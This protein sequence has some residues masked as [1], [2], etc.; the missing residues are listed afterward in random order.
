MLNDLIQEAK[1]R[2]VVLEEPDVLKC[3]D[4]EGT[5][6]F[7]S[8]G[9]EALTFLY[10]RFGISFSTSK[11]LYKRDKELWENFKINTLILK[12]SEIKGLAEYRYVIVNNSVIFAILDPQTDDLTTNYLIFD[13][14]YCGKANTTIT[15]NKDGMIQIVQEQPVYDS[16]SSALC[17]I[18]IDPVKGTYTAYDG[19]YLDELFVVMANPIIASKSFFEFIVNFDPMSETAMALK[20]YTNMVRLFQDEAI[21]DTKISVRETID[22]LK[23]SKCE[24]T[25]DGK[26]MVASTSF[27]GDTDLIAFLNSFQMPYKSLAQQELLKKSLTYGSFTTLQMLKILTQNYRNSNN[28]INASVLSEFISSYMNQRT[29][30][31]IADECIPNITN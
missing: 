13:D 3:T 5:V 30:R 19:V 24:I 16:G 26:K 10:D 12:N 4:T 23:K 28:T 31:N 1:F 22:L 20:F 2:S 17:L 7:Y 21:V 27:V 25:L 18:D 8:L 29:D 6:T 14:T 11:D 9:K 15:V